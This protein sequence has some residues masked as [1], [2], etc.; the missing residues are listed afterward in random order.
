MAV[1][2]E[3]VIKPSNRSL[4]VFKGIEEIS[5]SFPVAPILE[6]GVITEILVNTKA[7]TWEITL[8]LKNQ[9]QPEQ[10]AELER[11]LGSLILGLSRV[12]L[13]VRYHQPLEDR[14]AQNWEK[15]INAA[16]AKY[17]GITAFL[18][19]A[20][21]RLLEGRSLEIQVRNKVGVDYLA[22]RGDDLRE[23][24]KEYV[25][26][27]LRLN[28][29][30]GDFD[31]QTIA[32]EIQREQAAKEA[33]ALKKAGEPPEVNGKKAPAN[34]D[35]IYGKKF[36]GEPV[37]LQRLTEE[38]SEVIVYG[39]IF[40]LESRI[41]KNNRKFYLGDLTD[42]SD[43]LSFKIFPRQETNLEELLKEGKWVKM[44][45]DL[46]YDMYAK[47]LSL[48][49]S[50]I[51]PAAPNNIRTEIEGGPGQKRV[52]L[53]LHT[54][55]SA[56]DATTDVAEALKLAK[57]WGHQAIAITDH[58]VVQAYPE[59]YQAAKKIGIKV[60][61]GLEGYLVDD[62]VP[63]VMGAAEEL[64]KDSTYVAFDLETT[65]FNPQKEDLIELGAVKIRNGEVIE[66]FKSMVRPGK[67][68][69]AEIQKLTGITPEMLHDAPPPEE[70][71]ARFM[72]FAG[73]SVLVAHNARFD[74]NFLLA[75]YQQ[76]YKTKLE[77]VFVDT[78]GLARSVW[79]D[80]KNYRLNVLAK[81]L[82][83]T[84]AQH[85]RAVDDARCAAAIFLKALEAI[86]GREFQT[87]AE[88]NS[89]TKESGVEH[90]K[91]FHI[92]ILVK[93]QTG[94]KNL[95]RLVSDS[96]VSYFHRHP[97]IPRSELAKYREGLL[98]GTACESGEFYQA[99]LDGAPEE[100]LIETG[101]FYDFFEIQP[102]ANNQFLVKS[103]RVKSEAELM[104]NNRL[105]CELG[106]KLDKPVV[107]TGD[108]HF[109]HPWEEIYRRILLMGQGYEDADRQTPLYFRTTAEMLEEFSYLGPELAWEVVVKNPQGI[110]EQISEV[111]PIPE[112]FYPPKIPGA[113]E[114]IRK[115]AYQRAIELYGDPLP[116]LVRE[117]LEWELKSIIGHG[118]AVL[119][120]IAQKLVRKSLDDGYLVGSRGSV[121]SSFVATMCDITEVNPLPAHYRCPKCRYS[122]FQETGALGSGYDL[123]DKNCPRCGCSLLKDGQDI[124]FATFMGFEGDKE[125]DIDL[126]FSGEY[127]PTVHRYTEQLFGKGYVYRA[128][129]I[130]SLAEK[131]AFGF[132]KGYM[133][134]KKIKL[135][136][137]EINRLVKGCTGVRRSTGQH[138]GGM[139]VIPQDQEIYNFTPIQ[140]PANDRK[141]EWITT[142]FDF[143]GA[144]EGRL[145]KLDI[146]GHD[147]PT[148]LRM[149]HDITGVDPRTAPID[150]PR[151]LKL[152]S[153]AESLS[154]KPEQLGFDLGTL[155]IPEFGTEFVRQMLE[156]TKPTTISE[157]FNIS[158][159]SHGTNVWLGNAQDL[160]KN[161]L[162]KLSEVISVRDMIM[163]NLILKGLPPKTAFKIMEKVRKGKGLDPDDITLMKEHQI[164]DWYIQ[165]CQKIKYLFPK[166]HAVA[167]V[168]SALRIAYYKVYYPEAFYATYFSVRADEFDA[169]IVVQGESVIKDTLLEIRQKGNE[170]TQKEKNLETIL[171]L[172]L[173]AMYRGIRFLRV[174]LYRSDPQ[175]FIITDEGLLPPLASLQGLGDNAAKYLAE[176]RAE[177]AFISIEDLKSRARLSSAV[178]DVLKKHGCLEGMTASDQLA[179]F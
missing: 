57:A 54:K 12:K 64:V 71:L 33:E 32:D 20:K 142:H 13:N 73:Q 99:I 96:H 158:G 28:F 47:E 123:P 75:K 103:G 111:K 113:D 91:T 134:D 140:Y 144:L 101:N 135:R 80:F 53:H 173:E 150:D 166:A 130:T 18:T 156:D 60:I 68:I 157:L 34:L 66:E 141:A 56:M 179:L 109:L 97:R 108:V 94:L 43:S 1:A 168:I 40:R 88:L 10:V 55:M 67:E 50:D 17:P 132:V 69:P 146:L 16:A 176:A 89:L 137:A 117:R 102:L 74:V 139:V 42:Y 161:G 58:G 2:E 15:V 121:G 35:V 36:S 148:V 70:V 162:A 9:L 86:A 164:P 114:A 37:P 125:P 63:I 26:E 116:E 8:Y 152:F 149:L 167:Y 3:Y 122:E 76:F 174:D 61:Y 6:E 124:Q 93:N 151:V 79:P 11:A 147:D 155:G 48:M 82:G 84:L 85:H 159:L 169:E 98:L 72:D 45:G 83:I 133:E 19:D 95:Y 87:L 126:N 59:V 177:A 170:A 44:R 52:E 51:I 38:Q 27:E 154:I 21:Y 105:I 127:Q 118:Y 119:Y 136:Q 145:V 131:M 107:A 81:E 92:L 25:F 30:V 78:L 4:S 5:F 129:T 90:L 29:V 49:V 41:S 23:L 104:E 175:K 143:H 31:D 115:M 178:I 24:L 39:E 120:L 163:N 160:I 14:L 112:S 7:A 171:E 106:A 46:Q 165:S 100:R 172:V 77:P 128:G 65:G 153:S 138:P 110:C 62:G 22:P